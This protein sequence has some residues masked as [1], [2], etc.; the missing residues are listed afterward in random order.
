MCSPSHP[1]VPGRGFQRVCAWQLRVGA[2]GGSSLAPLVAQEGTAPQAGPCPNALLSRQVVPES[3]A[4]Q[5][6]CDPA[7]Q[8]G[9]VRPL[10]TAPLL[11][12]AWDPL[13]TRSSSSS[14]ADTGLAWLTCSRFPSQAVF[15]IV[16]Q[17]SAKSLAPPHISASGL[18]WTISSD[19][20]MASSTE[21]TSVFPL[22]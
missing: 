22:C 7:Q 8:T 10:L 13:G 4:R 2:P 19:K 1:P 3:G 18:G 21:A 9:Q 5:C 6:E 20:L 17:E 15:C 12:L 14:L 11:L 16:S